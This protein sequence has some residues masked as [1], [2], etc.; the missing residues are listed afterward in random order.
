[1]LGT[2][3]LLATIDEIQP[4]RL[5][6][7]SRVILEPPRALFS[8]QYLCGTEKPDSS[9]IVHEVQIR[10]RHGEIQRVRALIDCGATS[11]FMAPRLLRR[12]GLRHEPAFTSTQGL[13][14][15][16]MMSAKE[17][18]KTSFSVQYFQHLAPVDESEVLVVPMKTY[19]LVL[20][21]PWF[22]ARNPDIDWN[23]GRL[24][25]LRTPSGDANTPAATN[26]TSEPPQGTE[27]FRLQEGGEENK[28]PDI[29]LLGATAF[30][31]LLA[32]DEVV[33]AFAIRID[34]CTGLLGA[35]MEGTTDRGGRSPISWTSEQ[36]Q[37]R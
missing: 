14:G 11:I 25:S 33:E 28:P 24:L 31:D 35:C 36:E 32:S 30:D 4:H 10:D 1:M 7:K 21:L 8:S 6:L 12:L 5:A 2:R 27:K 15:Q 22:K 34:D 18:Q 3:A 37:R 17:S 26:V 19:D 29:H 20:G 9:H 23:S 13:N 16:I